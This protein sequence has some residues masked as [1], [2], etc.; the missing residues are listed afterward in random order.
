MSMTLLT[1]RF[2]TFGIIR[3]NSNL[4]HLEVIF[5]NPNFQVCN[6]QWNQAIK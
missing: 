3:W 1:N 4:C 2:A 5:E 6:F